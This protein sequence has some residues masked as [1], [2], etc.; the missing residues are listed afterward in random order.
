MRRTLLVLGA[1]LLTA[2]IVAVALWPVYVRPRTDEPVRADAILVLGGAHD[3]R[4]ELGLQLAAAG[5]A[6]RVLISNP[7][8]RSPLV[9][10][11]CHGGYS[12]EVICF[13]PSP[14]TTLGEGRE[15]AR[16]GAGWTRVIV[17]TFTPHISR[18][19]YILG[20][21]WPGELLFVDPKPHLS[22]ARWAWDYA[23]QSAGYVKAWFQDC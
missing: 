23:Y 21:C 20:K 16:L 11:I 1:L 5:Y 12:F 13:D 19:R 8:E 6:P 10:R 15:L 4:E 22:P 18:S 14:R 7:Y 2:L 3:G 17:V 9:N